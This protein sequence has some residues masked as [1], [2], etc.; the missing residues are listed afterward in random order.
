MQE[1]VAHLD[2]PE[3]S[4]LFERAQCASSQIKKVLRLTDV[5]MK[6]E[7]HA[8]KLTRQLHLLQQEAECSHAQIHHLAESLAA[9]HAQHDKL[10]AEQAQHHSAQDKLVRAELQQLHQQCHAKNTQACVATLPHCVCMGIACFTGLL[11]KSGHDNVHTSIGRGNSGNECWV[12][13][14]DLMPGCRLNS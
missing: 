6:L 4:N 14:R 8:A 13:P 3:G 1:V 5:N 10:M 7:D 9:Q 12:L 2:K 11:D